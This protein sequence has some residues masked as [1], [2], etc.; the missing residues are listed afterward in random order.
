MRIPRKSLSIV[1]VLIGLA[2]LIGTWGNNVDYLSSGLGIADVN[3]LFWQ[4]TL[5]NPASRSITQVNR[6]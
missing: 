5:V 1:Y 6:L 4:E 2:G 3:L